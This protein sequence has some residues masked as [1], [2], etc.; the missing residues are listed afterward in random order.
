MKNLK[1]RVFV[2]IR[3]KP[4]LGCVD[5]QIVENKFP[6]APLGS[7]VERSRFDALCDFLNHVFDSED[8]K[9]TIEELISL[10]NEIFK[11]RSSR[12]HMS[13]LRPTF[14]SSKIAA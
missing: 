12:K 14:E 5:G 3:N 13:G 4:C 7:L 6:L 1:E 8:P 11:I 9:K 2:G 10:A